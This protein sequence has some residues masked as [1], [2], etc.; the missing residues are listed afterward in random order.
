MSALAMQSFG[1]GDQLVRTLDREGAVWFVAN[2]VCAALEINNSRQAVSRLEDDEKDGVTISDA[3]G[4]EQRA[5][6]ISES[7]VYALIFRSRKPVAVRFR[8]WVTG[9]VLPTLRTTG[10]YEIAV[11]VSDDAGEEPVMRD[12]AP[13]L[14]VV[15]EARQVFPAAVV[16]RMWP[17][18]GLPE[19]E[20][21]ESSLRPL[22]GRHYASI[23]EWRNARTVE[24]RGFKVKG[25]DLY[26][27]YCRWMVSPEA[28]ANPLASGSIHT[29]ETFGRAL[30]GMGVQSFTSNG[31]WRIGLALID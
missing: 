1:F 21:E 24:S 13:A 27:D 23:Y 19:P 11:P 5:S 2:D 26:D 8:K 22:I 28:Q 10:R 17:M 30:S 6:I 14:A 29:R 9:E 25:S 4:R 18:L 7:G 15:R 3:I 12:Y 20:A 31:V 16:R